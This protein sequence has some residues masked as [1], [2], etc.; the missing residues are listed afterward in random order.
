M[1]GILNSTLLWALAAVSLP[2]LIHFLTRRKLRVV[3]VSTVAFLKRLE[4][5]KIRQLKLRQ[6]LLLLLR[7]LIVAL[8]VLAFSRPTLRREH[9]VLAQRARATAVF[10]LD[11]SLSMAAAPAGVSLL[12]QARRH[13]QTIAESFSAGDELFV[14]AAAR[15]AVL[16]AG[17]PF[18]EPEKLVETI[19]AL[20][21]TWAETDLSGALALARDVLSKSRNVNRE[22]YLL[23]DC[24][25]TDLPPLPGLPGVRGYLLRSDSDLPNNL[26]L[27]EIS[28]ANQI[29]EKGKSFEVVATVANHGARASANQLVHLYLNNKRVAQQSV[30][31]PTGS[32]RQVTLRAIPDSA[33]FITGRVSLDEDDFGHDNTRYFSFYIPYRRRLLAVAEKPEDLLYVRAALHTET[34]NSSTVQTWKEISTRELSAEGFTNYDGIVLVNVSRLSE[35]VVAR[36]VNF[37]GSGGGVIVFP[38][39]E[40]D[41]RHYNETLF[42]PINIGTW[43]GTMGGLD[44][45]ENF[46]K[47]GPIDFSHPIFSNVFEQSDKE[48]RIESPLF[49]FAV[50]FNMAPGTKSILNYTNGHA[51]LL[52]RQVQAGKILVFTSAPNEHWSDFSFKGL[53]APLIYRSVAYVTQNNEHQQQT[54]YVGSELNTVLRVPAQE[55][56]VALPTQERQRVPVNVVGQNYQVR[57]QATASPGF[58]SLWNGGQRLQVWP[59]NFNAAE[60]HAAPLS[61]ERLAAGSGV[62]ALEELPAKGDLRAGIQQARYGSELWRLFLMAAILAMVVEMLLYRSPAASSNGAVVDSA[63]RVRTRAPVN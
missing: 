13:A 27:A 48:V 19:T 34:R 33:G 52:E 15:P 54:Y 46:V 29:F 17:G 16:A 23:S 2:I 55:V 60:L 31:V 36:L 8:L 25:S 22:L 20:P 5:E 14:I 49:R 47:L 3:T 6:W 21:Q 26:T 28:L 59:V 41:L 57:V 40:T 10:I 53:F 30:G 12:E 44:A 38:G 9:S 24:R 56:E 45:T 42:A 39:S 62:A 37:L 63:Q 18:L 4:K 43:G 51:F 1:F 11:N 61:G 7:M 32:Q 50:H 35:G 58:Y